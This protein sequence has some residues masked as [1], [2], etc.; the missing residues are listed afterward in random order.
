LY[1]VEAIEAMSHNV[2]AYLDDGIEKM[3]NLLDNHPI[4]R[5]HFRDYS[6]AQTQFAASLPHDL[7]NDWQLVVDAVRG[8]KDLDRFTWASICQ[9]S[10][11]RLRA[12]KAQESLAQ[13]PLEPLRAILGPHMPHWNGHVMP[14]DAMARDL[15]RQFNALKCRQ[16]RYRRLIQELQDT[17]I[18]A[19]DM[20]HESL[21][22][23]QTHHERNG[24]TAFI[25]HWIDRQTQVALY[26]YESNGVSLDDIP[27]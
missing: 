23:N 3:L 10:R 6:G 2:D 9:I 14:L 12:Q 4:L 18:M 21:E 20:L 15:D 8:D 22:V 13:D 24:T 16:D 19:R 17:I 25:S 11:Q 5:D 26:R 7:I 1:S 27:F